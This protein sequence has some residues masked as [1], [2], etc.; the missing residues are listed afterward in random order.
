MKSLFARTLPLLVFLLASISAFTQG[1]GNAIQFGAAGGSFLS[2]GSGIIVEFPFAAEAWVKFDD[3]SGFEGICQTEWPDVLNYHGFWLASHASG[4]GGRD[5]RI[6]YGDGTGSGSTNRQTAISPAIIPTGVWTHVMGIW[7]DPF[8]ARIYI[9]GVEQTV[10]YNGTGAPIIDHAPVSRALIGY[11]PTNTTTPHFDGQIDEVRIWDVGPTEAE[12]RDRMCRQLDGTEA[13]LRGYW[14]MDEG[15]GTTVV[16]LS[17]SG[18]DGVLDGGSSLNWQLSGAAI[19]DAS[20]NSYPSTPTGL[21]LVMGSPTGAT[22]A[23]EDLV[24]APGEGIHIYRVDDFPNDL[25][26]LP[27]GIPDSYWGVFGSDFSTEYDVRI[28]VPDSACSFCDTEIFNRNDNASGGWLPAAP[29]FGPLGCSGLLADESPLDDPNRSEYIVDWDYS[30]GAPILND[31]DLEICNGDSLLFGGIWYDSPT[32]VSDTLLSAFGCDSIV[33]LDL[34]LT[35]VLSATIDL[36]ICEGDSVLF[37]GLWLSTDT[38]ASA[39][40]ISSGGCDSIATLNLTVKPTAFSALTLGICAGDSVEVE[41]IWYS[42]ETSEAITLTGPNGCDSVILFELL[43]EN[44]PCYKGF[45]NAF[46]PN[47][48]G[49][50]DDFGILYTSCPLD[51]YELQIFNRWG[52]LVFLSSNPDVRWDGSFKGKQQPIGSYVWVARLREDGQAIEQQTGT[53]TLIR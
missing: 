34:T 7:D 18:Q 3:L 42:E 38:S 51:F 48:D 45:P 24:S 36:D 1:S 47:Q 53:I 43:V 22:L 20:I 13:G 27:A 28:A 25:G 2:C 23:V 4:S 44:C 6:G 35:N 52:E 39:S 19:G 14:R 32:I 9:N 16:D 40:F 30:P 10:S 8:N 49:L 21:P 26:G 17:G 46:S 15:S 11:V 31:L 41:G 29:A 50:N 5:V 33:T 12:V 37:D